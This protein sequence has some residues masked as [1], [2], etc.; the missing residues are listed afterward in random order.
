MTAE[1]VREIEHKLFSLLSD[2]TGKPIMGAVF[3]YDRSGE[4]EESYLGVNGIGSL[5]GDYA[6]LGAMNVAQDVVLSRFMMPR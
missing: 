4:E 6:Q 2:L 5:S 3:I 1:E